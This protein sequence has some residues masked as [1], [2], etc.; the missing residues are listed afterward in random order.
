MRRVVRPFVRPEMGFHVARA[1]V[2]SESTLVAVLQAE[3]DLVDMPRCRSPRPA[4]PRR[5][6]RSRTVVPA[7]PVRISTRSQTWLTSH[8]P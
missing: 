1:L 5:P 6:M 3:L 4:H 8:S 2:G 7:S